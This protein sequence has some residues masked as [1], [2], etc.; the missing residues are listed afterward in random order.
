M[1]CL[2]PLRWSSTLTLLP[3]AMISIAGCAPTKLYRPCAQR[4]CKTWQ[5]SCTSWAVRK[6]AVAAGG[7]RAIGLQV[8]FAR[9]CQGHGS[10]A[11]PAP[12]SWRGTGHCRCLIRMLELER[13][14]VIGGT[15]VWRYRASRR[16]TYC[17]TATRAAHRRSGLGLPSRSEASHPWPLLPLDACSSALAGT[18]LIWCVCILSP[19]AAR[20]PQPAQRGRRAPPASPPY[21]GKQTI[22]TW[23][24]KS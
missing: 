22:S 20:R 24:C 10:M 14:W 18:T 23:V 12:A 9:G 21:P 11:A 5:R 4:L 19:P 13:C 8:W 15:E 1:L 3:V 17:P 2:L 7:C 16:P 6:G